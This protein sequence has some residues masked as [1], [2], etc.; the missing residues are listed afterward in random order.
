MTAAIHG[1][2]YKTRAIARRLPMIQCANGSTIE[3]T[4]IATNTLALTSDSRPLM[5][6]YK[7][8]TSCFHVDAMSANSATNT[9]AT[10]RG[11]PTASTRERAHPIT[12]GAIPVSL[13]A[14]GTAARTSS[15]AT[16]VLQ[17]V[18]LSLAAMSD[19]S[20]SGRVAMN[21]VTG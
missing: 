6:M 17:I 9:M 3:T 19:A 10:A 4:A 11:M 12:I 13:T 8:C 21:A 18:T 15:H 7:L 5:P 14:T 20:A 2:A 16:S 1:N